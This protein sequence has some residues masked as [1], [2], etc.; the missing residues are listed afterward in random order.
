MNPILYSVLE[1]HKQ[2]WC[3]RWMAA[4]RL[5]KWWKKWFYSDELR[6][7][8]E[9]YIRQVQRNYCHQLE[10]L[11]YAVNEWK[12]T[13]Y[14]YPQKGYVKI[15]IYLF[16]IAK[17][18][19]LILA[20][21][22]KQGWEFEITPGSWNIYR[23]KFINHYVA[24]HELPYINCF[25]N[26]EIY[27][28]KVIFISRVGSQKRRISN[29]QKLIDFL[30]FRIPE[31]EVCTFDDESSAISQAELF[32]QCRVMIGL[33]GAGLANLLWMNGR[34][35]GVNYIYEI[36]PRGY[37]FHDYQEKARLRGLTHRYI[38][39][40]KYQKSE[41]CELFPRDSIF[42]MSDDEMTKMAEMMR[43]DGIAREVKE[44]LKLVSNRITPSEHID[45][46]IRRRFHIVPFNPRWL[47]EVQ[48]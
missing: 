24:T 11:F 5:Q 47:E 26:R 41:N 18:R 28:H 4:Y 29:E 19:D 13:D 36:T 1:Q 30:C 20:I 46:A 39:V 27:T 45:E 31:L 34:H 21:S 9:D 43:T 22:A 10:L 3:N 32:S 42:H 38:E 16:E 40:E 6:K 44:D 12:M 2:Q 15:P 23:E 25:V 48:E 7:E 8:K 17:I 35:H 33:H 14:R 37:V